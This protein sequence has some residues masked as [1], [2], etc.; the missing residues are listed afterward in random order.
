M[1]IDKLYERV[2]ERSFVCVG[3]DTSYDYL[4]DIMKKN[5]NLVDAIFRFNKEII[6]HTH[7]IVSI[8]KL[9]IAYYEAYGIEGM[10]AYV[11]TLDYL[12]SKDLL[13]ISDV[14]RGDIAATAKMYAKA[15]F[16]S[17]YESDFITLSP[18]MGYDS[19]TPYLPY[20]ESGKKGVFVLLRTSNEGSKDIECLDY[21][22]RPLFYKIGD[23]LAEM[24][25]KYEGKSGYSPLGLVVGG[26]HSNEAVEIRKS[27]ENS[28]FLIPGYGHQGAS[29]ED[30]RNYLNNFNGGVVNSSRGIITHFKK[31]EDGDKN[32]GKY[33][34]IAVQNMREDIYGEQR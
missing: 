33:S 19:I 7:D 30:I 10:K 26:T 9:Q 18:Y 6:D 1:I 12:K 25:K 3:L 24:G 32:V 14:K 13:I 34:R 15:Y 8:Y 29:S 4:P 31:Y 27:Y 11:K 22:G 20:L 21:K 23:D 2:E 16:E 17:Q 28:F 5:S